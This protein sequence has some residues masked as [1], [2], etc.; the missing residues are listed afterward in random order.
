M[1]ANEPAVTFHVGVALLVITEPQR[2]SF[3]ELLRRRRVQQVIQELI[4]DLVEGH[5]DGKLHPFL[6]V[7]PS[8]D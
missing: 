2:D 4:V 7:V 8:T 5:P 3:S 1:S 6:Q